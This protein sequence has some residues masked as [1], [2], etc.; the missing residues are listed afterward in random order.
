VVHR[1]AASR[2]DRWWATGNGRHVEDDREVVPA[3]NG[4]AH[5]CQWVTPIRRAVPVRAKGAVTSRVTA[6]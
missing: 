3:G 2:P 5:R 6:P 4:V 1:E